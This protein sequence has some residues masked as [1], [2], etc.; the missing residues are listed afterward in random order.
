MQVAGSDAKILRHKENILKHFGFY[1]SVVLLYAWNLHK[2][3]PTSYFQ[4][5]ILWYSR[6]QLIKL[7]IPS[8]IV[9]EGL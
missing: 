7:V 1:Q 3:L 4:L 8:S 2:P 9:V 5:P 6:Y